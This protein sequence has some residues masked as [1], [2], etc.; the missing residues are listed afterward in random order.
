MKKDWINFCLQMMETPAD[1]VS[2]A[3]KIISNVQTTF[4]DISDDLSMADIGYTGSKLSMLKRHYLVEESRDAV[5]PLW[6][7][8]LGQRKYGS[9]SFTTHGHTTKSDPTKGSKRASVLTPCIQSMSLTYHGNH[10]TEAHAFYRTTEVFKKFPADLVFIRDTLLPPFDFEKAPLTKLTFFFANVTVHPMYFATLAPN[11]DD[12]I[13]A[14]ERIEKTDP[15]FWMWC[16]KWTARYTIE[17]YHR[18]IQKYAQGMRVHTM[19]HQL[20]DKDVLEELTE[21]VGDNHPGMR[22]D[23]VDPDEGEE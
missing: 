8:R 14:L 19:F 4:E 6:D 2:G 12:P 10:T 5:V 15:H 17:E 20:M 9:V 21:Y 18:G 13:E 11:L 7:K 1:E 22:D 23:Y 16:V 3:R